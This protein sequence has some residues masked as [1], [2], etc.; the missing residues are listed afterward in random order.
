LTDV[1]AREAI[2]LAENSILR[3]KRIVV[4][5]RKPADAKAVAKAIRE[6][7]VE[8]VDLSGSKPKKVKS[9]PYDNSVEALTGTMRGLDRDELVEKPVVKERWLNGDLNPDDPENQS[10]VFL[11]ST[12]AGEVGFDL[13]AD[14]LVGDEAPLDSWIQRLGRVNRRGNGDAAVILVRESKPADKTDFEK[15]CIAASRLLTEGMDVSPK[16]LAI[17][18]KSLTPEQIREASAPAPTTVEL[19]DILLDAWSMTSITQPMPGRPEVGPWLRGIADEQAQTT[20]AWRAELELFSG[21]PKP[22][23]AL[24]AI[25]AKHTI[26]P[27]ESLTL[28]TGHLLEILKQIIKLKDRP[29]SLAMTR[30]AVRMPRGQVV[31]RTIQQLTDYPG[32][33]YADST[34]ILPANFGGL[35]NSGMLDAE[36]IPKTRGND[37]AEPPSLDVAD[38]EGYEQ[39]AAA[40]ARLRILIK[41]S[42]TGSWTPIALPGGAPIPEDIKLES[43]YDKS[44]ALFKDLKDADL[45][46][47]LRQPIDIDDE[48]NAVRSL[49]VLAPAPAKK[50]REDQLLTDHVGAV[51]AEATRIADALELAETDPVRIAL[52]FAAKWHDEG[53][54]APVWQL[55]ANNPKPGAP[56]R[57]KMAQ[58]RDPK[59][60]RGYRH[61]F[62]SLLRIQHPDRCGTSDCG[63]PG[64]PD[65]RELAL[66]LITAHHGAGRPHFGHALYDPFTDPER[67]AIHIES[68]RRFAR[69]QRKYGWWRLAWLEDLLRCADAVASAGQDAEDDPADS[70]GDVT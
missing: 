49:V 31:C 1:L 9:T 47:R 26:R 46:V 60:L 41:R 33:L 39:T 23:G 42:E 35:D 52:L 43:E 68:I 58:S 62:G 59:S 30:V 40:R 25:F 70:E 16:A 38:H 4:F 18:R 51:E 19:T 56:P 10:L 15:A 14:H 54:K 67:D 57:G 66:H 50:D 13:N 5:V 48:G 8:S 32:I 63:P 53:K 44:T 37:D 2:R 20:V 12:S 69:L 65:A 29:P 45:R 6:H 21:D 3:A 24:Q 34:L 11:I 61:E 36:S 7:V 27:H 64:G 55:F 22:E 17:F 28:N